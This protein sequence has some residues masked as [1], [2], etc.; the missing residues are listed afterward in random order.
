MLEAERMARMIRQRKLDTRVDDYCMSACIS[1][2]LAGQLRTAPHTAQVGFHQPS[3]PGLNARDMRG[4]TEETRRQYIAAGVDPKFLWRALATPAEDI[5]VPTWDELLAANVLTQP[6]I[7]IGGSPEHESPAAD[8]LTAQRLRRELQ[9]EA[10]LVN[11]KGPQRFD[12]V[13]TLE[14][15]SVSDLTLTYHYK[16][17]IP[18]LDTATS[19]R[20]LSRDLRRRVCSNPGFSAAITDGVTIVYAYRNAKRHLFDVSISDCANIGSL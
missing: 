18:N 7:V 19:K 2:L 12:D 5:W 11:G 8:S 20:N 15:A 16:L 10:Q 1:L 17:S 4:A 6:E 13:T 9:A 14:R 3:F